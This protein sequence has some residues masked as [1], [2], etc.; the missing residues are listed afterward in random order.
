M[1]S[2]DEHHTIHHRDTPS[3]RGGTGFGSLLPLGEGLG[4]RGQSG[5][6]NPWSMEPPII[7]GIKGFKILKPILLGLVCTP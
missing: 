3:G 7:R 2:F 1:L 4:M 5:E 6:T